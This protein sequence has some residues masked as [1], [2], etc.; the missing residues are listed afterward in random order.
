[1]NKMIPILIIITMPFLAKGAETE[2]KTCSLAGLDAK[3][4]AIYDV[5]RGIGTYNDECNYHSS[6]RDLTDCS[7]SYF[8][9]LKSGEWAVSF[10]HGKLKGIAKCSSTDGVYAVAGDPDIRANREK[11]WEKQY[12]WCKPTTYTPKGSSECFVKPSSWFFL[13]D[14]EDGD[15]CDGLC[16]D[17]CAWYTHLYIDF[18]PAIFGQD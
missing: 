4:E 14:Y 16:A 12:C 10:K 9:G 6:E 2:I 1:M 17:Q 8:K 5:S 15:L 7:N 3:T 18:R 11:H 13:G